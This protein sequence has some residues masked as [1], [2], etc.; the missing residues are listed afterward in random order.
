VSISIVDEFFDRHFAGSVVVPEQCSQ[1]WINLEV[2]IILG[3]DG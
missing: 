3:G 2:S 1:S